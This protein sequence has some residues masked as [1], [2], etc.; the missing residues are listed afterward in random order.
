MEEFRITKKGFETVKKRALITFAGMIFMVVAV[1][2]AFV[3]I[4]LSEENKEQIGTILQFLL[5]VFLVMPFPA[6]VVVIYLLEK[7]FFSYVLRIDDKVIVREQANRYTEVIRRSEVRKIAK[8]PDGSFEITGEADDAVIFIPFQI[9]R[10]AQLEQQLAEI[11]PIGVHSGRQLS[12]L[13]I[14]IITVLQLAGMMV[15][16]FGKTPLAVIPAGLIVLPILVFGL[17][18][19]K[20]EKNLDPNAKRMVPFVVVILIFAI[21]KKMAES[22]SLF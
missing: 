16:F 6:M 13:Q 2:V 7:R 5:P 17:V 4:S 18:Q 10:Y 9:E 12:K 19:L 3:Y 1:T 21:L 15:V 22:L 11:A 14:R 20:K 8:R